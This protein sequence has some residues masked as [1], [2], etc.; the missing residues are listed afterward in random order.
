MTALSDE[1]GSQKAEPADCRESKDSSLHS[2][3]QASQAYS[4]TRP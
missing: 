2:E 4:E 3:F 1:P